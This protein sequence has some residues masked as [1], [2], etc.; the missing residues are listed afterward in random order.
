MGLNKHEHIIFQDEV[1]NGHNTGEWII[2]DLGACTSNKQALLRILFEVTEDTHSPTCDF[3]VLKVREYNAN[4]QE[5]FCDVNW[6]YYKKNEVECW[7]DDDGII[8]YYIDYMWQEAKK[9][10]VKITLENSIT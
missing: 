10:K 3:V 5:K 6:D 9:V 8:E 2:C 4:L 1:W 7:T